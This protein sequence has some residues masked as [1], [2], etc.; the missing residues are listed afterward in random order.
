MTINKHTRTFTMVATGLLASLLLAAAAQP[1]KIN[2]SN[3]SVGAGSRLQKLA[4]FCRLDL[5]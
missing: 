4:S 3:E 5:V 2:F 1:L